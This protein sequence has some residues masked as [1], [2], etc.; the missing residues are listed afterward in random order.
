M[1]MKTTMISIYEL[2]ARAAAMPINASL[3]AWDDT[4]VAFF[5]MQHEI[6]K[7]KLGDT[8]CMVA[9]IGYAK[10]MVFTIK[11]PMDYWRFVAEYAKAYKKQMVRTALH[12]V[13]ARITPKQNVGK[14]LTKFNPAAWEIELRVNQ[15]FTRLSFVKAGVNVTA[16][17]VFCCGIPLAVV[18]SENGTATVSELY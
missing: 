17:K 2:A 11:K 1:K 13:Y 9:V 7:V 14:A 16:T 10:P 15:P 8:I 4:A 18:A 3:I 12:R 5:L 6:T